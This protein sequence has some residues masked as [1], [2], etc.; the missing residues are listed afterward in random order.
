MLSM[1]MKKP[2][3]NPGQTLTL[4]VIPYAVTPNSHRENA[5]EAMDFAYKL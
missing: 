2:S 1:C 4:G 3:Q 5:W